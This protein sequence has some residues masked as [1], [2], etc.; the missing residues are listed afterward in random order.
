MASTVLGKSNRPLLWIFGFMASG[1][2]AV[3]LIS[4]RLLQTPSPSLE[5]AKLT[6]PVQRETLSVEIKASGTV[7]PIQSVNISPKNPGRLMRLL[8]EQGM[9][10]KQGQAIAVMDNQEIVAQGMQAEARAKEAAAN[11]EE[12]KRRI[13]EE[14]RQAQ[15]RY[16]QAQANYKQLEARLSQARERI[17]GDVNQVQAQVTAAQSRFRLSENRLKRNENLAREGA[18]SSDQFDAVLNDYLSAKAV[19]GEAIRKL[20]Q[21]TKTASPEVEG[22]QQEMLGASAAIAEA[23]F[24]LEQRQKTSETEIAR[25]ESVLAGARAQL[26]QVKI[27]YRDTLITAPFDG[28][29]TQKYATEGAF[30]TPTTSASSTASAT[31]TSIVA[32]ARGLEVVAKVPEVDV[33][34]LQRGQPVQIVADAFPDAMFKG[35][36][37]R[38]APEAIVEENVTSFEVTIG[39]IDG[40]DQLK[41]KMN[42]DVTFLGRP[43]ENALV[44]P[45]VAIVTREGQ[46]GVLVPDPTKENQPLFKPVTIGLVMDNKTQILS[47]VDAG[48]KV[49]IDLPPGA[50]DLP[51]SEKK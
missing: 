42:V 10:V 11:L 34:L 31:S 21:T 15:A 23:K 43:K 9:P 36:V 22:I 49:F 32:L 46:S 6:V 33:G 24:A 3:G 47:G 28:I 7:E 35:Q 30:V 25:L 29:V 19:L 51:E 8:V 20:E 26:E 12:A 4:Y 1:F 41:S 45:T 38:I 2:L 50:E 27:Q 13:P 18:I 16:Y 37:I 48:E 5:L 39:L 40:Q 14:I 44:V 17:P